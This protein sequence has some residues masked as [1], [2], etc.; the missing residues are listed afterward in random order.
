[1]REQVL[2]GRHTLATLALVQL[3]Q[4]G[5]ANAT[6]GVWLRVTSA[7]GSLPQTSSHM[8]GLR[9]VLAS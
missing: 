3:A 2:G 7:T 8:S 4:S 9:D 6:A 5:I 1:M